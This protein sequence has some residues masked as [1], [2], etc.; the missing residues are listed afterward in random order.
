VGA[1][2]GKTQFPQSQR[3]RGKGAYTDV[4]HDHHHLDMRELRESAVPPQGQAEHDH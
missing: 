4:N 1:K 2:Y 3:Q